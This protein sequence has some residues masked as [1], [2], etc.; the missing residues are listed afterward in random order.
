MQE[1]KLLIGQSVADRVGR[2]IILS[3]VLEPY[4]VAE[5][6]YV[7]PSS[8]GSDEHYMDLNIEACT[9]PNYQVNGKTCKHV[10]LSTIH[11]AR[12]HTR[13]SSKP[14]WTLPPSR[15]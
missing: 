7:C 2:A 12:Y 13:V 15:R 11:Q 10:L 3:T 8:D 14:P 5:D 9:C 1:E 4:R 6:C